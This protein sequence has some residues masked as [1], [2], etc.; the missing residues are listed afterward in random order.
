MSVLDKYCILLISICRQSSMYELKA[1][2]KLP[3][4]QESVKGFRCC[5]G[6]AFSLKERSSISVFPWLSMKSN[7]DV[8]RGKCKGRKMQEQELFIFSWGKG[9]WWFYSIRRW[10][11]D[12]SCLN[13]SR[14][15]AFFGNCSNEKICPRSQI[16][17][18]HKYAFVEIGN[19]NVI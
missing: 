14:I 2:W 4:K 7:A 3:T 9:I 18:T 16:S 17:L 12:L 15:S 6:Q 11:L 10:V 8:A 5:V 1:R 13:K 19:L